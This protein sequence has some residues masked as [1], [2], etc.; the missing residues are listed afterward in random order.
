MNEIYAF[1][2]SAGT[3]FLATMDGDQPRVRPFGTIDVFDGRLY[4]RPGN[5]RMLHPS[6]RPIRKSSFVPCWTA[7]N[8]NQEHQLNVT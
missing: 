5:A 3:Y 6:S 4:V 1:L 8:K 7:A 2:K